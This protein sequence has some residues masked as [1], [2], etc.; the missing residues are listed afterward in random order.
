MKLSPAA[1]YQGY[2]A[3]VRNPQT[4]WMVVFGTIIY[5]FSPLDL[6]PDILPLAG[7]LDDLV[8]VT[9]LLTELFQV[10][11]SGETFGPDSST[12]GTSGTGSAA[13]PPPNAFW[14]SPFQS[15]RPEPPVEKTVDVD[16]V[17]VDD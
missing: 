14:R 17:S 15:P 5:L 6:S 13:Q 7:Q 3:L 4:R 11:R 1:L 2:R 8:L 10:S 12:G 9:L 16:A